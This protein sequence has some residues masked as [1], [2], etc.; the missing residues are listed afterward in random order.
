MEQVELNKSGKRGHPAGCLA[1]DVSDRRFNNGDAEMIME[2]D[3][4]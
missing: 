4:G 2:A 1:S 3:D